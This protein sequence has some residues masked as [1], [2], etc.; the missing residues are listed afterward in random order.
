MHKE[1]ELDS[2]YGF[3]RRIEPLSTEQRA[4]LRQE[5]IAMIREDEDQ[6]RGQIN[7]SSGIVLA[8]AR[9]A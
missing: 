8:V 4:K 5:F 1:R 6:Q 7:L 2:V 3:R 9:R